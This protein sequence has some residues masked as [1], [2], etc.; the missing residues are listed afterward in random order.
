MP[1]CLRHIGENM[2]SSSSGRLLWSSLLAFIHHFVVGS[3]IRST[4]EYDIC[5]CAWSTSL[6]SDFLCNLRN[7]CII[8]VSTAIKACNKCKHCMHA[9]MYARAHLHN[10]H[11]NVFMCS[12]IRST[13]RMHAPHIP[14]SADDDERGLLATMRTWAGQ[15]MSC[16]W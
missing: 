1:Q 6:Y 7:C 4:H 5:I 12:A 15:G 3:F 14:Q 16:T 13:T 2:K 9:C 8:Q 10:V 11:L